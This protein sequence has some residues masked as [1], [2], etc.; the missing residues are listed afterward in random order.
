MKLT[1]TLIRFAYWL[2]DRQ[3]YSKTKGFVNDILNNEHSLKKRY[4]DFFM[5]FLVLST[6]SIFIYEIKNPI[7]EFFYDFE[8][9]AVGVFIVEWLGRLW[10]CNSI[11][12]D[13]IAY[14]EKR[15]DLIMEIEGKKLLKII[16]VK[17]LSFIFSPMSIIDLLAILPY[18][19]P[20]RILRFF[21]LFRLFKLMR[22]ANVINSLFGVFKD[23]RFDL[24]VL[25]AFAFFVLFLA[26]TVM[27]I[28]EGL[29]DNPNLN[30]FLDAMYW[31]VITMATVGY[32]DIVPT[33]YVGK[34]VS[35]LLTGGG[36][37]VVVL[38]TS[39]ITSAFAEKLN[40]MR[41]E[42]VKQDTKK[43]KRAIV[44]LG[45]GRMGVSLAH[46]LQKDKQAFVI[47]DSKE[48]KIALAREK[49][50]I[51]YQ[52]DVS[53]YDLLSEAV[54]RA[55]VLA[56]AVLT[57]KDSVNLS[58]LLA[59][60]ANNPN[61]K[62][63]VRANEKSNIKK[64]QLSKADHVVFPHKYVAHEAVEYMNSPT[65]FD[66]LDS[67][68]M[69]KDGIKMD[70]L[71]IPAGSPLIGQ[72]LENLNIKQLRITL[73]GI[74]SDGEKKINFR[75]KEDEYTVKENDKLV[76]VGIDEQ[77]GDG[78]WRQDHLV[79]A[80]GQLEPMITPGKPFGNLRICL[81]EV[82]VREILC[83]APNPGGCDHIRP[84]GVQ[85]KPSHLGDSPAPRACGR[86]KPDS[87]VMMLCE[88]EQQLPGFFRRLRGPSKPR[89]DISQ[90]VDATT[91][92]VGGEVFIHTAVDETARV[93]VSGSRHCL[94]SGVVVQGPEIGNSGD[95]PVH[96]PIS[97]A[98]I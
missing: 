60:K 29:G 13:L 82:H 25:V 21:L 52:G 5:I 42:R 61:I 2:D 8:A 43:L 9:F 47:V 83:G 86:T 27:Y 24:L 64:F 92:S 16:F 62:V 14:H 46:M 51:A 54:F 55:D 50:F 71:H 84:L 95:R 26:S 58:V 33:T 35:M 17:K 40:I 74:F 70:T 87:S 11:H 81:V 10:T 77:I 1:N 49:K 34:A 28:I 76:L 89:C 18:Y 85:L 41:E 68:V 20:L 97:P 32:G 3:S 98:A 22:Y 7:H 69:E 12:K 19:R 94:I 23:K 31:A 93:R 44:I 78:R 56:V 80:C 91:R 96:L 79:L 66:A 37:L 48:E 72:K 53:D 75:P 30:T 6:I 67:I 73:I 63:I 59:I 38:A 4:F 57:D 45:F 39:I 15:Q 65:T 88:A 36:L 90:Q